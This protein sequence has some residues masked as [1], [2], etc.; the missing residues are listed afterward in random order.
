MLYRQRHYYQTAPLNS[1]RMK[2]LLGASYDNRAI[3]IQ[4]NNHQMVLLSLFIIILIHLNRCYGKNII[5]YIKKI[6][7]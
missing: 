4:Q 1:L 5:K 7:I 6:I 3:S 2:T